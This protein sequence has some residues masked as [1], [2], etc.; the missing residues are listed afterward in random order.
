MASNKHSVGHAR[1][2]LKDTA[3]KVILANE[4]VEAFTDAEVHGYH[5]R[6]QALGI[7]LMDPE[8][9]I[10]SVVPFSSGAHVLRPGDRIISVNGV[11]VSNFDE[12]VSA[13]YPDDADTTDSDGTVTLQV[14]R[15]NLV[16]GHVS[17]L[18][19]HFAELVPEHTHTYTHPRRRYLRHL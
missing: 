19:S 13:C 4:A 15:A 8:C 12:F 3:R 7:S 2:F 5:D 14:H 9:I 1:H 16:I 17:F 6:E 18:L 10:E 11:E